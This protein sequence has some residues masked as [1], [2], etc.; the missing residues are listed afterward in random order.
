MKSL[1]P[2][3]IK[4]DG[5]TEYTL[6]VGGHAAIVLLAIHVSTGSKNLSYCGHITVVPQDLKSIK[7]VK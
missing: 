2:R 1:K 7:N 4:P 5:R 3:Y 6:I